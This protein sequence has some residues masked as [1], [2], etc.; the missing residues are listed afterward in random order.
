VAAR[1][2]ARRTFLPF[3]RVQPI[4]FQGTVQAAWKGVPGALQDSMPVEA[5]NF[6][7]VPESPAPHYA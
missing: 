1:L 6:L 5:P 3:V 7:R 4:H 2:L